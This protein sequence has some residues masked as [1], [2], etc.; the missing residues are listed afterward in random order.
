MQQQNPH[1]PSPRISS[2]GEKRIYRRYL[3]Q[4]AV[5]EEKRRKNSRM[6][7]ILSKLCIRAGTK[8]ILLGKVLYEKKAA[9]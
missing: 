2:S 3:L 7:K 5:E 8:M 9:A 4:T 6:R 1:A